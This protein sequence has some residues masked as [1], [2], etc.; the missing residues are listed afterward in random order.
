M[1]LSGLQFG[2][3]CSE[4]MK[5]AVLVLLLLSNTVVQSFPQLGYQVGGKVA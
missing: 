4:L 1:G 5:E 2:D 3:R